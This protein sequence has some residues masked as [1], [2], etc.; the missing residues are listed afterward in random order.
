MKVGPILGES[1]KAQVVVTGEIGKLEKKAS[2]LTLQEFWLDVTPR[3]I[4]I[5][6]D[7][8]VFRFEGDG[9]KLT[10]WLNEI[11]VKKPISLSGYDVKTAAH[12]LNLSRE[13]YREISRDLLLEAYC[14]GGGGS[15]DLN[16][17]ASQF[18]GGPL[19]EFCQPEDRLDAVRRIST[20]VHDRDPR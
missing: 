11:L 16:D 5:Q 15:L 3:G 17:L 1:A 9:E 19:P 10:G 8:T 14:V 6:M 2:K 20:L 13:A 7:D 12:S 18:L 4:A